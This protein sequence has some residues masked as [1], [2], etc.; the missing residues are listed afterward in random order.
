MRNGASPSPPEG[1]KNKMILFKLVAVCDGCRTRHE[2][3]GHVYH[4]RASTCYSYGDR[5]EFLC[6]DDIEHLFS[7]KPDGWTCHFNSG[8]NVSQLL[9]PSCQELIGK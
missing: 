2:Y 8:K 4:D 9:C 7:E 5:S 6:A 1:R 3:D